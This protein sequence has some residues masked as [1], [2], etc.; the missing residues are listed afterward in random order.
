MNG[1]PQDETAR[2]RQDGDDVAGTEDRPTR[3]VMVRQLR[4]L[5]DHRRF[6]IRTTLL[7]MGL[8][9]VLALIIPS[10]FRSNARLM[11]PELQQGT[12]APALGTMM[13]KAGG[14]LGAYAAA[15]LG[16]KDD[17]AVV[18]AIL[19]SRTVQDRLVTKFGLVNVYRVREWS[20][21][22]K[23]LVANTAILADKKSGVINI[24]V[25]DRSASRAAA[26]AKTYTEE[27]NRVLSELSNTAAGR[28]RVFLEHRLAVV[29]AELENSEKELSQFSSRSATYDLKDQSKSV[30]DAAALLEGQLIAAE[31]ELEGLKPVYGDDNVRIR[32]L[33]ARIAELKT[34]LQKIG[35]KGGIVPADSAI[36]SPPLRSLPLLGATYTGLYRQ[37]KVQE[38]VYEALTQ[39]YELARVE[40]AKQV[41]S[42]KVLDLPDV[43]A[44]RAFPPRKLI[45]LFAGL[46]AFTFGVFWLLA[47]AAWQQIDPRDPGKLLVGEVMHS[48]PGMSA[49]SRL[50]KLWGRVRPR[51]QA[52]HAAAG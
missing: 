38:A 19:Q 2:T 44:I 7:G 26:L 3:Q 35:G 23:K 41:P 50:G 46:M 36:I 12:M 4:L 10:E 17:G 16:E 37:A 40:E 34:S 6:L 21:A 14:N 51:A 13:G 27:L 29:K 32:S 8:G 22:R 47:R 30:M 18:V 5:W 45:A 39:Q 31:A 52:K 43:P 25:T 48:L 20:R 11:P 9:G 24:Q 33:R 49:D 28:E 42:V 15:Q 1:R